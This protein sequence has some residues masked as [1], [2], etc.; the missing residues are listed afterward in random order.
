MLGPS[1]IYVGT[2]FALGYSLR[3]RRKARDRRTATVAAIFSALEC[4]ALAWLIVGAA[5]YS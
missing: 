2:P 5:I 4:V 1:I 3:A